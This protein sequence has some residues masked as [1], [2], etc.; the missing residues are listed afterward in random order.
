VVGAPRFGRQLLGLA[1]RLVS[2]GF[3]GGAVAVTAHVSVLLGVLAGALGAV[4]GAYVGV[5]VRV[6][7]IG[8]V[9]RVPA[10][11]LEDAVAI[12]GAVLVVAYA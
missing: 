10:A 1:A 8:L 4:I 7:A 6:R 3:C 12:V 5:F 9:G 11:L 2:G